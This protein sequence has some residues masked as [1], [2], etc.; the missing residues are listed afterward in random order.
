ME[1]LLIIIIDLLAFFVGLFLGRI[2]SAKS[3]QVKK[4]KAAV[5]HLNDWQKLL[6]YTPGG[7]T[8]TLKNKKETLYGR[9]NRN[10]TR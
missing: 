5:R 8:A 1:I 9:K 6:Y 10:H 2:I 3:W 7:N 4:E